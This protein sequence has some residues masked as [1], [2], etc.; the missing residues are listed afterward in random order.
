M[1]RV[2]SAGVECVCAAA[3][4]H[5]QQAVARIV[6]HVPICETMSPPP[7]E[8]GIVDTTNSIARQVREKESG[9]EAIS[10]MLYMKSQAARGGGRTA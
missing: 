3:T 9:A 4:S 1:A 8:K 7:Q 2:S 5:Q 6:G 10:Q